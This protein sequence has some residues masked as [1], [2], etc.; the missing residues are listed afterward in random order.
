[1]KKG[2]GKKVD[3]GKLFLSYSLFQN[4]FLKHISVS[5]YNHDTIVLHSIKH[6]KEIK[7]GIMQSLE[8]HNLQ[9]DR[10]PL[11]NVQHHIEKTAS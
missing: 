4:T 9:F 5:K 8:K 3:K 7:R 1:M 6:T 10:C 11:V 2:K